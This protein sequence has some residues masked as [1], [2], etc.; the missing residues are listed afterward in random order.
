MFCVAAVPCLALGALANDS[1]VLE[2]IRNA[3]WAE[4]KWK[5]QIPIPCFH[6]HFVDTEDCLLH[7]ELPSADFSRGGVCLIG[8][9]NL[10]WALRLWDLPAATRSVIHNFALPGTCHADQ[11]ALI[12]FL[13]ERAGLL[14]A[15]ADKTLVVF[16]LSY[17]MTHNARIPGAEPDEYFPRLLTRRGFYTIDRAGSIQCSDMNPILKTI[18]LERAKMTGLMRELVNIAYTPIKAA[19]VLNP[20]Y[21]IREWTKTLGP[22]WEEKIAVDLI[23]FGRTL[24]CLRN[25]HVRMLV[26]AM[27]QASWNDEV[28]FERVYMQ[29]LRAVCAQAGVEILDLSRSIPDDDFADSVH[30]TP[31]GIEKFQRSVMGIFLDHLR[32]A[33]IEPVPTTSSDDS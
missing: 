12:R 13:V 2:G 14:R 4:A 11:F 27:P 9:S 18:I 28:P 29:R 19:R 20:P 10:T 17:H 7:H 30:L 5:N 21:F 23:S 33:G 6:S 32:S 8:A 3:C 16:G 1:R 31:R 26:I 25:R 22:R 15:G 24:E